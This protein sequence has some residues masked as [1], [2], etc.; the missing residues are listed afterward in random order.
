MHGYANISVRWSFGVAATCVSGNRRI[1]LPRVKN[2]GSRIGHGFLDRLSFVSAIINAVSFQHSRVPVVPGDGWTTSAAARRS[3]N[4]RANSGYAT[5]TRRV[6]A[7]DCT[8]C[9]DARKG[10]NFF[11][12]VH[13][14]QTHGKRVTAVHGESFDG[15]R[16]ALLRSNICTAPLEIGRNENSVV[17]GTSTIE[18][19]TFYY[20]ESSPLLFS[21]FQCV[22]RVSKK[23]KRIFRA[24]LP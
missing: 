13:V 17:N 20:A 1:F 8:P 18:I 19:R 24:K 16:A 14:T 21:S 11:H 23:D 9:P 6:T 22:D 4:T 3:Q 5:V 12:D 2:H 7:L 15:T 10:A